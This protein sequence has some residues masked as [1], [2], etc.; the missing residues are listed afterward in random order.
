MADYTDISLGAS[1]T[2]AP[3]VDEDVIIY[4][5]GGPIRFTSH[6]SPAG[7]TVGIPL[8]AGQAH[9]VKAGTS[10]MARSDTAV[11]VTLVRVTA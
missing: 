10:L 6:A 1:W 5:Q 11:P 2:A 8:T 9:L 3:A 4:A 7:N